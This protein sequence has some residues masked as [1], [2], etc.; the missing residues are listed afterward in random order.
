MKALKST[1]KT[2]LIV[3]LTFA[4]LMLVVSYLVGD[5]ESAGTLLIMMICAY[6]IVAGQLTG[7]SRTTCQQ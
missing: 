3:A 2:H 4:A 7:K 6:V 5:H 1:T